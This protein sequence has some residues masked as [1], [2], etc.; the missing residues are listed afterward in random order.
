MPFPHLSESK[1]FSEDEVEIPTD[2]LKTREVEEAVDEPEIVGQTGRAGGHGVTGARI[3]SG[4]G[5]RVV[6]ETTVEDWIGDHVAHG[7]GTGAVG[8][9]LD[10]A[11][12]R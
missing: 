3:I 11:R 9:A 5:P 1:V 4:R 8:R 7:L 12:E 10:A 2:R 6:R